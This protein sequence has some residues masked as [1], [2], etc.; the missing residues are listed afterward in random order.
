MTGK[1][2][3]FLHDLDH[4]VTADDEFGSLDEVIAESDVG[5][6]VSKAVRQSEAPAG[7]TCLTEPKHASVTEGKNRSLLHHTYFKEPSSRRFSAEMRHK[8]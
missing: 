1:P 4:F 8:E 7:V 2:E 6:P 5:L 3:S